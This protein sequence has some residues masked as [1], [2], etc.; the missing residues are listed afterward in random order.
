MYY[1]VSKVHPIDNKLWYVDQ[2]IHKRMSRLKAYILHGEAM[3]HLVIDGQQIHHKP[4]K[5]GKLW[6]N[7][8][9]VFIINTINSRTTN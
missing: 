9:K 8:A 1:S 3:L 5:M 7:K 2:V 6:Q 4:S